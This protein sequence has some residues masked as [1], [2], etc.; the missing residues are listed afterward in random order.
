VKWWWFPEAVEPG[1]GA[2]RYAEGSGAATEAMLG[3]HHAEA[4]RI[5][6]G[7]IEPWR[8]RGHAEG[9]LRFSGPELAGLALACREIPVPA[10]TLVIANVF[11]VHARGEAT[12]TVERIAMHGSIRLDRPFA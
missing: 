12:E 8:G 9:S 4:N 10:D 7:D 2:F 3:F 11:G 1:L 5:V 6:R